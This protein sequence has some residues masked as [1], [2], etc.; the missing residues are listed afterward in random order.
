MYERNGVTE[1]IASFYIVALFLSGSFI[2]K[3]GCAFHLYKS[4]SPWSGLLEGHGYASIQMLQWLHV[5]EI[6]L[7]WIIAT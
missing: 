2:V 1:S 4:Q 5:Y 6:A 7:L 3:Q